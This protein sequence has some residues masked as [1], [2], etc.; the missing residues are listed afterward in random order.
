LSSL[1]GNIYVDSNAHV[2]LQITGNA[3]AGVIRIASTGTNSGSLAIYMS[4]ASF[5]VAS[6]CIVDG[7]LAANLS[8]Y[9][10]PSNTSIALTGNASFIGTIYAPQADFKLGGGGSSLYEF[11]GAC[12]VKTAALRRHY[13][14]H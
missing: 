7:G 2:R 1:S 9:G 8:Y 13:K 5:T 3:S 4:G 14:F 12:L 10:L 11:V 6:G